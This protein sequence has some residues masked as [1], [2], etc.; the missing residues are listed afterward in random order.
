MQ[1][2]AGRGR[3]CIQEAVGLQK[4]QPLP[5]AVSHESFG[6]LNDLEVS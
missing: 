1:L 3:P 5:K 2:F 4:H 6:V